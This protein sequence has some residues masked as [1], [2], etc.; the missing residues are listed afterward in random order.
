MSTEFYDRILEEATRMGIQ[1]SGEWEDLYTYED[2]EVFEP[3]PVCPICGDMM[4]F[5][6]HV[7]NGAGQTAQYWECLECGIGG[8]FYIK[9]IGEHPAE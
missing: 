8:Y 9:D 2:N 1:P 7:E 3:M 6:D 4:T 5:D